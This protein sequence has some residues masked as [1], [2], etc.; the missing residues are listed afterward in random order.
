MWL[1]TSM[2]TRDHP[3]NFA[4]RK[5]LRVHFEQINTTDNM[6]NGAPSILLACRGIRCHFFGDVHVVYIEHSEYKCLW[7][8][9]V[10]ELKVTVKD[11]MKKVIHNHDLLIYVT[12]DMQGHRPIGPLIIGKSD[13]SGYP[14]CSLG[15]KGFNTM[16]GNLVYPPLYSGNEAT[17]WS[18]VV[19][20]AQDAVGNLA[21]KNYVDT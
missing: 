12:L 2:Y 15:Q 17:S 5:V 13:L 3:I 10:G 7:N 1:D 18:Q 14:G 16:G 9:S 21:T 11:V 6:V 20:L 8:G 4:M 19:S